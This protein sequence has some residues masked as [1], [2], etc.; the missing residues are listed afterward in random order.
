MLDAITSTRR[1]LT[2]AHRLGVRAQMAVGGYRLATRTLGLLLAAM[3]FDLFF[4]LEAFLRGVFMVCLATWVVQVAL[5]LWA[6]RREEAVRLE[7]AAIL[8]EQKHPELENALINAV[9]FSTQVDRQ[10]ENPA[11]PLMRLEMARAE[12]EA[13][14]LSAQ[15]GADFS[16]VLRARRH[17]MLAV[18]IALLPL[19]LFP[20]AYRFEVPRFLLFWMDYPP[21]TLTDFDVRPAGARVKVGESVTIRVHV[22]GLQPDSLTLVTGTGRGRERQTPLFVADR[23]A[24]MQT[25]ENLTTDTWYYVRANTG[26]SARYLIQVDQAPEVRRVTVTLYHPTYTKR[27]P[28]T[29]KLGPEGIAGLYGTKVELVVEGTRPLAGGKLALAYPGAPEESVA[30]TPRKDKPGQVGGSFTIRRGGRYRLDLTATDGLTTRDAARG[31]LKLLRDEKPLVYLTAPGRNAVVTP[32]MA[33]PIRVEAEDDVGLQRIELHR[34]VNNLADNVQ[35][36]PMQNS[37]RIASATSQ[38]DFRDLGVR[39]GDVI[40]YYATAYDN[41]P[42]K[43][44]LTDSDRYWLWVVSVQDYERLLSQ[45]RGAPEMAADYRAM[46]EAL[47]S[48]A[49]EQRA[50]ARA[51]ERLAQQMAKNP[52]DPRLQHQMRELQKTQN[53]LRREAQELAQNMRR[54]TAQKPQYDIEKGLQKKLAELARRVEQAARGAMQSASAANSPGIMAQQGANAA[55]Q[56]ERASGQSLQ[57]IE[58][59]LQVLE[60]LAPLYQDIARLKELAQKQKEIAMQARQVAQQAMQDTFAKSRLRELAEQQ[61]QAREVLR[62]IQQ[63]LQQH[64]QEC[65]SISTEAAQRGQLLARA[66]GQLGVGRMM[67]GAESAFAR[68]DSPTGAGKA[69]RAQRALESLFSQCSRGH[70]AVQRGL[71]NQVGIAL[72]MGS[73]N[74]LEQLARNMGSS[75]G[76]SGQGGGLAQ[77]FGGMPAPR[78]GSRPGEGGMRGDQQQAMALTLHQQQ[79]GTSTRRQNRRHLPG[80]ELPGTLSKQD[81][82]KLTSTQRKPDAVIDPAPGRYPAEYRRLVQEYFRAVASGR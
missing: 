56:L 52:H 17:L 22:E 3:V 60:K 2:E 20:R 81:V 37:P 38:L 41:D 30:L 66:L 34:I 48:L 72:G 28:E 76:Q 42:G 12:K 14:H 16:A 31:E 25:L 7:R 55:Q 39:P 51:M 45:Q 36:Y 82:E 40:Q 26:R 4:P 21:F 49:E 74:T 77:G 75:F 54:L 50:L 69:E 32:G 19:L 67:E 47:G 78:P 5:G 65:R 46:A 59:A 57:S 68:Q 63:D 33:V 18:G 53:E 9:Q 8:L 27:P 6:K 62:S 29:V 64:A 58:K 73:G 79:A 70:E 43:P 11:T 15:D 35:I 23:G 24:Y 13:Q 44:N 1:V 71:D 10:P 61:R 80:T